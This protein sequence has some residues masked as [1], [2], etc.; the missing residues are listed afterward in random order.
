MKIPKEL[1]TNCKDNNYNYI[2]YSIVRNEYL[3]MLVFIQ[4]H[5]ESKINRDRLKAFFKQYNNVDQTNPYPTYS[6]L[7]KINTYH[8]TINNKWY[9]NELMF[10]VW[11]DCYSELCTKQDFEIETLIKYLSTYLNK[12]RNYCI[13]FIYFNYIQP[14]IRGYEN[15]R[16]FELLNSLNL[17][18]NTF[19]SYEKFK[20]TWQ[21]TSG[22]CCSDCDGCLSQYKQNRYQAYIG[23]D[24]RDKSEKK[25]KEIL[26]SLK[27]ESAL[28]N[29]ENRLI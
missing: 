14:I 11:M 18:D 15:W 17:Y 5:L 22:Y 28:K 25:A 23:Y 9:S 29:K 10:S 13:D 6:F 24:L 19:M 27:T 16:G 8:C 2:N 12:P 20:D 26:N 21:A 3:V 7:R 1:L 4:L